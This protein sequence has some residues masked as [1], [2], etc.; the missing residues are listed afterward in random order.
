[1]QWQFQG[2][3]DNKTLWGYCPFSHGVNTFYWTVDDKGRFNATY[4]RSTSENGT[5]AQWQM[6]FVHGHQ[7]KAV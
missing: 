2:W 4:W 5:F 7:P 1:M 3:Y 6:I